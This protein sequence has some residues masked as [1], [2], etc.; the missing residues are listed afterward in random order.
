MRHTVCNRDSFTL[1]LIDSVNHGSIKHSWTPCINC[2]NRITHLLS[3]KNKHI[4]SSN[5]ILTFKKN[6][7]TYLFNLN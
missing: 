6:N 2:K 5:H 1:E 4:E 7:R 3:L